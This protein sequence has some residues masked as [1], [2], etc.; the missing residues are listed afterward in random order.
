MRLSLA[1]AKGY[2]VTEIAKKART[3]ARRAR[4]KRLMRLNTNGCRLSARADDDLD[5]ARRRL[6]YAPTCPAIQQAANA[7]RRPIDAAQA[8]PVTQPTVFG[9]C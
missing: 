3:L 2:G 8:Q 5:T 7:S 4:E 9:L 6:A 1:G